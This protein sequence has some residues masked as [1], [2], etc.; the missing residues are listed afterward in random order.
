MVYDVSPRQCIKPR[1]Q[2]ID[3]FH[4]RS[5]PLKPLRCRLMLVGTSARLPSHAPRRNLNNFR[6]NTPMSVPDDSAAEFGHIEVIRVILVR[7]CSSHY[8]A[9]AP[10]YSQYDGSIIQNRTYITRLK[11]LSYAMTLMI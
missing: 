8:S 6:P 9:E 11:I 7:S 5:P 4:R 10:L 1:A 2:E 3:F